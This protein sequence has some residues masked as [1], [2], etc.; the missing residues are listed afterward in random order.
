MALH[1]AEQILDA[2]VAILRAASIE[3]VGKHRVESYQ[4]GDAPAISVRFGA[5]DPAELGS[6]PVI[7]SVLTVSLIASAKG[8]TEADVVA[9]LLD[10]RK[11]SHIA[12]MADRTLGLSF[13][14]DVRYRGAA[15]PEIDADAENY[16][17]RQETQWAVPYRMNL[18]DPS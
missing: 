9:A 6:I 18:A 11:R 4:E 8:A 17:G 3:E 5:D 10:L 15:A 14:S 7:D 1:R 12:L 16:G 2:V 13:V